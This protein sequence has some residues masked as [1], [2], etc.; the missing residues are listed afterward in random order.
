MADGEESLGE[1]LA[2]GLKALFAG[3]IVYIASNA[4]LMVLLA[5]AFLS[6]EQFGSLHFTLSV[7]GVAALLGTLGLPK[8]TA[9]YLTEYLERDPSQI[10]H[11]LRTSLLT[12][13][14][15]TTVV[16]VGLALV[17]DPLARLLGQPS[18]APML[19][20]GGVYVVTYSLTT[21]LSVVFQ[22]FDR[23]EMSAALT[24]LS[25]VGR[26]VFAVG[27]VVA[28]AGAI[29][30]LGGYVA[31]YALA[32]LAGG[33]VL[34]RI[35]HRQFGPTEEVERGLARRL[36]RYSLPLT[37]TK[38]AGALDNKVDTILVGVLLNPAAVSYYVIA[39][40]IYTVLATPA[41]SFGFTLSPTIGRQRAIDSDGRA[42]RLYE[43]S[44]KYVLLL[45]VPAATG[46]A[47]VAEPAIRF[48]FGTEYLP[49]APVLQVFCVVL[50]VYTVNKITSDALD[51]LG[52]A[53]ARAAGKSAMAVANALLN[54]FL[55]PVF[56]VVGAAAATGVTYTAYTLFN[57]VIIHQ[58]LSL[59]I[60]GLLTHLVVVTGIA[61]GMA[62][63]V[64]VTLPLVSGLVSLVAVVLFGGAV[65][66]ALSV[67]SGRLDVQRLRSFLT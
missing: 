45:Y 31:G 37:L 54:V 27:F 19:V 38:G 46:L 57:V 3:R 43:E 48:V 42:A 25:G 29:G 6:P 64:R 18:V 52:R 51:Y 55:I 8:S 14:L 66:M 17:S 49:A 44:L 56:G 58:E 16:G 2:S 7:L 50:I 11:I 5:R 60:R 40:Q 26:L 35:Y 36:L 22:G 1:H 30:A 4:A 63:M 12:F 59:D 10:R 61:L 47:L 53:K 41:A 20:L 62:A 32:V 15:L 9:R 67:L 13:G 24:G 65:W 33:V 39:G 34:Y 23:V 21:H 28:G